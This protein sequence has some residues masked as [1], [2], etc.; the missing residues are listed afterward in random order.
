[1]RNW[2]VQVPVAGQEPQSRGSSA[3]LLL[4][5]V[6]VGSRSALPGWAGGQPG[7]ARIHAPVSGPVP[8]RV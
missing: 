1:M 8:C 7:K 3:M 4:R 2:H 6:A 5:A